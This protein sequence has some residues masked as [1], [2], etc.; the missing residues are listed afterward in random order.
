MKDTADI[1]ADTMMVMDAAESVVQSTKLGARGLVHLEPGYTLE[2]LTRVMEGVG[3]VLGT[4]AADD[5]ITDHARIETVKSM[6]E[7]FIDGALRER[8]RGRMI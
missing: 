5:A 2:Y 6:F 7:R 8:N 3:D 4:M 1:Y